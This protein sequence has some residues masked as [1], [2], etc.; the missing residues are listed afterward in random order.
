MR[1]SIIFN[2]PLTKELWR[3]FF[4]AHYDSDRT[5]K[6]RYLWGATCVVIGSF[7]FGGFYD[8]KVLAVLLLI[9]GFFGV[10]SKHVLIYKSLKGACCHPFFGEDLTVTITQQEL[11]VRSGHSG[12]SQPWDNFVGYRH[13]KPGFL[14]YH[15]QN[16]FFFIPSSIVSANNMEFMVQIL[17]K[18]KVPML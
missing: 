5:L 4:E 14:L 16:A 12:Y 9:T 6:M 10:L 1:E 11:T 3:E 13:L 7:G 2:Y 18:N 8:S 15:D 17:K